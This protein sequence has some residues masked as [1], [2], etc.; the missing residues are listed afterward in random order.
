MKVL[1]IDDQRIFRRVPGD[2]EGEFTLLV[3][4]TTS[5][6]GLSHLYS[7]KWD[8]V[9]LDHD[10]GLN[11]QLSGTGIVGEIEKRRPDV[12]EF[13]LCTFNPVGGQRMRKVLENLGFPVKWIDP[14]VYLDYDAMASANRN[15][16]LAGERNETQA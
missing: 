2:E 16:Y 9:I 14:T 4:A 6:Q 8:M 10:L 12:T 7:R 11:S 15:P 1:V 5:Q 13:I 3:H